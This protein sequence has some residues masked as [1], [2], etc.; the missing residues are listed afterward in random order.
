MSGST[1]SFDSTA[2]ISVD[3]ENADR[4]A[5]VQA[6]ALRLLGRRQESLNLYA[7]QLKKDPKNARVLKGLA[8]L[9]STQ[10]DAKA[11]DLAVKYWSDYA[12]L[13]PDAS[14]EWWNAKEK[15]VEIYCK[16]GKKDQAEKMLKT[17]W[18]TRTDPSDPN[19]KARWEKTIDAAR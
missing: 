8:T 2:K 15:C 16:T 10:A 13:A 6:D 7:K 14:P 1:F 18:L 9:L 12:D 4:V 3:K 11:L 5:I 17:L 19:R